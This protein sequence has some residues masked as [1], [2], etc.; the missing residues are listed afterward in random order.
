[1][2][3]VGAKGHAEEVLQL[4]TQLNAE[5]DLYFFDNM[6]KDL[7]LLFHK[8]F[9]IV[10][11]LEEAEAILMKDKRFV[12]GIG[13]PQTRHKLA[14]M[15][16]KA[17]GKLQSIISPLAAIGKYEVSLG[18]GLNVMTNVIIYN[19]TNRNYIFICTN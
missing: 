3:I 5:D 9:R 17:G 8:K 19:N 18:E 14:M 16:T 7:P 13:N 1:M 12:L 11:S 2:I 10:K 4:F 6:S 15:L